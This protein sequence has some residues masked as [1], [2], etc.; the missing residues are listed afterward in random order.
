MVSVE[1]TVESHVLDLT[2]P[3]NQKLLGT[4]TQ[5]LTGSWLLEKNSPT[6]RL[7]RAAYASRRIHAIKYPSSKSTKRIQA[8]LVVFL[9]RM[10]SVT[11]SHMVPYDPES[12]LPKSVTAIR[13]R[14]V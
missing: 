4:T 2:Q 7:G 10:V 13:R 12:T 14:V 6:Q 11:S 3:S 1:I 5:E 9:N 8:N